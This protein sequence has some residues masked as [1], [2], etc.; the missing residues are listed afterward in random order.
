VTCAEASAV[1]PSPRA[2]RRYVV[3]VLGV[4]VLTPLVGTSPIPS[5]T[6]L[7]ASVVRQL[8]VTWS[9]AEIWLGV[10]VICA[11][12]GTEV[13]GAVAAGGGGACFFLQPAT[14]N[15]AISII[16][17]TKIRNRRFNALLLLQFPD[18]ITILSLSLAASRQRL[19]LPRSVKAD[20]VD[21]LWKNALVDVGSAAIWTEDTDRFTEPL[22][23]Q[24][25]DRAGNS[26]S[27]LIIVQQKR[28]PFVSETGEDLLANCHASFPTPVRHE[29]V[30]RLCQ[31]VLVGSVREH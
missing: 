2:T 29:V 28:T 21:I 9:P 24:G 1:P 5:I 27:I 17:G 25:W 22:V 12:G 13:G 4:T 20:W 7:V 10:A 30:S 8:S 26:A 11:V 6:A 3:E 14:A 16:A 23:P 15:K 18:D 19:R 31:L